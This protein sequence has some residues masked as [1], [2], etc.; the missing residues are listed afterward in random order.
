MTTTH[1]RIY[2]QADYF[3]PESFD[4][5]T[6]I[7]AY[8]YHTDPNATPD[9][10]MYY[11]LVIEDLGENAGGRYYLML[12]RGEFQS[13]DLAELETVLLDWAISEGVA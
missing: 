9:R 7:G 2:T 8:T 4:N 13:D 3:S 5:E 6:P 10:N 12:E 1:H 11:N